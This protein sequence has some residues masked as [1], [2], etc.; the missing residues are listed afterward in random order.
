MR[1]AGGQRAE[2]FHF[3][4]VHQLDTRH[5][6]LAVTPGGQCFHT[7]EVLDE[8][9]VSPQH[10]QHNH[11]NACHRCQTNADDAQSSRPELGRARSRH[12]RI[13]RK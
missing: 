5:L 4:A 3:L 1:D 8:L 2:R 9:A 6:K 7:G 12:H 10:K 13:R 11:H